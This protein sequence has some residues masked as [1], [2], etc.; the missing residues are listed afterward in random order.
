MGEQAL[1]G[2]KVV[3]YG[4]FI[5]AA[6][7]TKMMADLGAEV[8]KIEE[9][10]FGDE[11]RR[12][13]PFP[14]DISHPEKSGLFLYLN[15]NKLGITLNVQTITGRNILLD[16]LREADVFVENNPPQFMKD[17]GIDY[18]V[19]KEINPRLIMTSI[20]AYGQTGP[21]KDFKGHD[22]NAQVFAGQGQTLGNPNRDP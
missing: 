21:Y 12:Y 20:T 14:N 4:E 1:S 2:L 11:S 22:L 9:P 5:S 8:I 16:L 10:G 15:A 19:L 6:Y 3:E 18:T 13:G 7:C 17:M